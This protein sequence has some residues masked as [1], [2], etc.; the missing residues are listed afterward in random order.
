MK[1]F[2]TY[3]L[4]VSGGVWRGRDRLSQGGGG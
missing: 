1:V 3:L 4:K 2:V